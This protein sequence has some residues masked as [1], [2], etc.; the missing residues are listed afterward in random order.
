MVR[1]LFHAVIGLTLA[2]NGLS[3]PAV[4]AHMDHASPAPE[5]QE[6]TPALAAQSKHPCHERVAGN[7]AKEVLSA[8]QSAGGEDEFSGKSCCDSA[9]CQCGCLPSLSVPFAHL[10]LATQTVTSIQ[11]VLVA[12]R[13][14]LRR[15]T[16]PFRPPAV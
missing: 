6:A 15:D 16:P 1:F 11:G 9:A 14:V 2:L 4:M 12:P 3:A 13:P 5:P 10:A 7:L 8:L